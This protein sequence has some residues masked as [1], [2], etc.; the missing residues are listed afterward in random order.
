MRNSSATISQMYSFHAPGFERANPEH[1]SYVLI[2]L[3]NNVLSAPDFFFQTEPSFLPSH[4][5]LPENKP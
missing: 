3:F 1:T 5:L 4:A 2:S